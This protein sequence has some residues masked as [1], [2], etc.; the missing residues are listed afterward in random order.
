[1]G[2]VKKKIKNMFIFR[3]RSCLVNNVSSMKHELFSYKYPSELKGSA[4]FYVHRCG[5]LLCCFVLTFSF[6]GSFL[7]ILTQ[8]CFNLGFDTVRQTYSGTKS[9]SVGQISVC[10]MMVPLSPPVGRWQLPSSIVDKTT[11]SQCLFVVTRWTC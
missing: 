8:P 3:Q 11:M 4:W 1:M 5:I 10:D 7:V 9:W 2:S 6:A